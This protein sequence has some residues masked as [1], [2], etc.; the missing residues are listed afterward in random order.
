[1]S[2]NNW[3]RIAETLSHIFRWH[4]RFCRRRVCLGSPIKVLTTMMLHMGD[5]H[6][7]EDVLVILMSWKY[8]TRLCKFCSCEGGFSSKFCCQRAA[9]NEF[10]TSITCHWQLCMLTLTKQTNYFSPL[11][12]L[13]GFKA[14]SI[15]KLTVTKCP[16]GTTLVSEV[17]CVFSQE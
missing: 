14:R 13:F 3:K 5:A 1:M 11:F 8:K 4:S 15:A 16:H 2:L 17:T 10:P 6:D 7:K 9:N 12:F